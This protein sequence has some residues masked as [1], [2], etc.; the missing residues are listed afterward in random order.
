MIVRRRRT[1]PDLALIEFG[2]TTP[3]LTAVLGWSR[4][5]LS[6]PTGAFQG[7]RQR[8]GTG[9]HHNLQGW[10]RAILGDRWQPPRHPNG[11]WGLLRSL[12]CLPGSAWR[13]RQN[14]SNCGSSRKVKARAG[15]S[16]RPAGARS[17]RHDRSCDQ[18]NGLRPGQMCVRPGFS[19]AMISWVIWR[20][21]LRP[22]EYSARAQDGRTSLSRPWWR[23]LHCKGRGLWSS[24][25]LVNYVVRHRRM[26]A[27]GLAPACEEGEPK[28]GIYQREIRSRAKERT[29]Q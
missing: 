10:R 5:R 28:F 27:D 2:D 4:R 6:W 25:C 26:K 9:L 8:V 29:D 17:Q 7:L 14:R 24:N 20:P 19:R 13:S 21:Y 16:R 15:P 11:R 1:S 22:S 18:K 12:R 23:D 3:V